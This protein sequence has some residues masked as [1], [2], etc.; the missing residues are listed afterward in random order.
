VAATVGHDFAFY[1]LLSKKDELDFTPTLML[2]MGSDK[3]TQTHTNRIFDR[4]ALSRRKKSDFTNK[5]QLQSVAASFDFTYMV[6][7]FFIQTI[8][9]LDYYLPETTENRFS[10]IFS[11]NAGFSF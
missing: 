6:K 11:V 4:P 10:T 1:N 2:N 8:L 5:F 7:K 9:Y 3:L